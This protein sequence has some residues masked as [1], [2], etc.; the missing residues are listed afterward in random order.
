MVVNPL[1]MT[2]ASESLSGSEVTS[3]VMW[4]IWVTLNVDTSKNQPVK[5]WQAVTVPQIFPNQCSFMVFSDFDLNAKNI[6]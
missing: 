5:L 1:D 2:S 4:K 3:M 6:L